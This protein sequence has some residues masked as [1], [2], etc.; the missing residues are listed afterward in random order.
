VRREEMT[1]I[2][3]RQLANGSAPGPSGWTGELLRALVDDDVCVTG[4]ASIVTDII[5][6]RP[7]SASRSYLLPSTSIALS[8]PNN[9][10]RPLAIGESLYRL[11][12]RYAV[13]HLL[14]RNIFSTIQL[15][16]NVAGGS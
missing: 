6:G 10:I 12:G 3:T 5:N 9:G 8:K 1:K 15:G 13:N 4:L 14:P 11:A 16:V 7:S 2:I